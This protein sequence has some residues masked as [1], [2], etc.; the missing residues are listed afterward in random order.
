[1]GKHEEPKDKQISSHLALLLYICLWRWKLQNCPGTAITV[2]HRHRSC[3]YYRAHIQSVSSLSARIA[4]GFPSLYEWERAPPVR[5]FY[6]NKTVCSSSL[7]DITSARYAVWTVGTD[8]QKHKSA[9]MCIL[10]YICIYRF[11]LFDKQLNVFVYTGCVS[12]VLQSEAAGSLIAPWWLAA[13]QVIKLLPLHVNE[14]VFSQN[15]KI[16]TLP[17]QLSELW[18]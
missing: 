16:I 2:D 15:K 10:Y 7:S 11:F 4:G 9:P 13:V 18:V 12:L 1:M 6:V 3:Y 14:W 8:R 5:P 17:I